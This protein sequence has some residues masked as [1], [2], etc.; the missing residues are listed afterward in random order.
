M[1]RIHRI[2]RMEV[3]GVDRMGRGVR[4]G[5]SCAIMPSIHRP[6]GRRNRPP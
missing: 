5:E 6:T 2:D 3:D 4:G 1:D